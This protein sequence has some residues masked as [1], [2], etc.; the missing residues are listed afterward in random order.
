VRRAARRAKQV[1]FRRQRVVVEVPPEESAANDAS[2]DERDE[3]K[4]EVHVHVHR[5]PKKARTPVPVRPVLTGVLFDW[6]WYRDQL[7]KRPRPT[8]IRRWSRV[9]RC[10]ACETPIPAGADYCPR[11][12]A[13]R[14]RR[15]LLPTFLAL[16]GIGCIAVVFGL[17]AHVLGDSVPEHRAPAPSG[18]WTD[19]DVMIVE[20]PVTPS[21]FATPSSGGSATG[22]NYGSYGSPSN[23]AAALGEGLPR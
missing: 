22:F 12:A 20:V 10:E 15:R 8:A 9:A 19:P 11:C 6:N 1:S 7:C 2:D 21:P 13:P 4:I 16:I 18:Q 23:G 14:A 17:C 5:G 3:E